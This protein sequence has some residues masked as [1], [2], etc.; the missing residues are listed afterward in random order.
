MVRLVALIVLLVGCTSYKPE[1]KPPREYPQ[2]CE[3]CGSEWMITPVRNPDEVIPP[4]VEWCFNDG[5]YCSFGL[6]MVIEANADGDSDD[7][8]K[9][10]IRHC[11]ECQGCR[12][13]SYSPSEWRHILKVLNEGKS[14]FS[15]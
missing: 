1:A 2:K 6:D 15:R 10:F 8:N 13:A 3:M 11:L 14:R 5:R 9:R 4:T 7:L 12:C